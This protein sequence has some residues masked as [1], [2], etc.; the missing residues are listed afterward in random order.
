MKEG[1]KMEEGSK[2]KEGRKEGYEERKDD[3]VRK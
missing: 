3:K 2:M 1:R